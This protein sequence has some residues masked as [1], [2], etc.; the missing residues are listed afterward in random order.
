[1]SDDAISIETTVLK[2]AAKARERHLLLAGELYGAPRGLVTD[3]ERSLLAGMMAGLV[4]RLA[5]RL[6]VAVAPDDEAT[7]ERLRRAGLLSDPDLVGAAYHRM[8]E[9]DLESRASGDALLTEL[10]TGQELEVV[11]AITEYRVWR[12]AR[13][14]SYGNPVLDERDVPLPTLTHLCWTIAAAR[15]LADPAREDVIEAATLGEVA[16]LG[17]ASPSSPELVARVLIEAGNVATGSLVRL[18]E[19]G[20]IALAEALIAQLAA[21]PVDFVRGALFERGGE[22]LAVVAKAAALGR[23]DFVAAVAAGQRARPRD[24]EC[25]AAL[26]LF[27]ALD[28]GT[29]RRVLARITRH[30][31][32]MAAVRR[33]EG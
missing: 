1:M 19:A 31:A 2:R 29:A 15:G 21:V 27:D 33:L 10:A 28:E 5:A 14:D 24:A 16:A 32:Y 26:A 25:R 13:I 23:A 7:V 8:L 12:A 9:F 6:D 4:A 30:S 18:I 17:E 20:E 22:T 11:H 3:A